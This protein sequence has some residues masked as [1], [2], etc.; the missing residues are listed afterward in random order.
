MTEKKDSQVQSFKRKKEEQTEAIKQMGAEKQSK[1]SMTI[2]RANENLQNRRNSINGTIDRK[3]NQMSEYQRKQQLESEM[4]DKSA[5]RRQAQIEQ[6]KGKAHDF[7][8]E[9]KERVDQK[10]NRKFNVSSQVQM[11]N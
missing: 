3:G 1:I 7:E 5:Q 6:A 10:L 11:K 4:R 8:N 2:D 9:T